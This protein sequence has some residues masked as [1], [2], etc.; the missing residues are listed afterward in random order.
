MSAEASVAGTGLELRAVDALTSQALKDWD[1]VSK[2]VG[3][4]LQCYPE[5]QVERLARRQRC[6]MR[7]SLLCGTCATHLRHG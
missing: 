6:Y 1:S 3:V 2:T 7:E 4:E 5:R